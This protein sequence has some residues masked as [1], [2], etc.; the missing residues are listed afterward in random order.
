[1]HAKKNEGGTHGRWWGGLGLGQDTLNNS[2]IVA[3]NMITMPLY[4][5]RRVIIGHAVL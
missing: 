5:W 4:K 3:D 1:M 2:G